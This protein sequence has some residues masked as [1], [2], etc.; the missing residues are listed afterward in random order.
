[1][2]SLADKTIPEIVATYPQTTAVFERFGINPTYEALKYE[3]VTASAKV[4]QVDESAL[5]DA[6]Q[7][8]VDARN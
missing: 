1:M 8:V 6:L 3:T 4:N 2:T 7:A 5:L